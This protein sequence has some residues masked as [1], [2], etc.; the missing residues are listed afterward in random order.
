MIATVVVLILV[1]LIPVSYLSRI[2]PD[3]TAKAAGSHSEGAL[4]HH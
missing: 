3:P 2:K 1:I 4:Y